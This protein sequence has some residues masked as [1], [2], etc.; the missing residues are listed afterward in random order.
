V[1]RR[2]N[3]LIFGLGGRGA[4]AE[5]VACSSVCGLRAQPEIFAERNVLSE[6]YLHVKFNLKI[7]KMCEIFPTL[8]MTLDMLCIAYKKVVVVKLK[9]KFL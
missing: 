1:G 9:F 3:G 7:A 5:S 6:E 8:N 4:W 2:L